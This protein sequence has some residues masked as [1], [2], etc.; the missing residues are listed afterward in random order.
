MKDLKVTSYGEIEIKDGDFQLFNNSEALKSQL[1][2]FFDTRSSHRTGNNKLIKDGE[3]P[4]DTD[5]GLDYKYM[6]DVN[7]SLNRIKAYILT[8]IN[9]YFKDIDNVISLNVAKNNDTLDLQIEFSYKD[10]YGSEEAITVG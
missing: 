9:T 6:L 2:I 3:F 10:I 1:A 4:L 5:F 8:K 7:I